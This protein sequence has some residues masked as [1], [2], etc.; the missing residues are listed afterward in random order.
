MMKLKGKLSVMRYELCT[1][2]YAL[3]TKLGTCGALASQHSRNLLIRKRSCDTVEQRHAFYGQ[4]TVRRG[5]S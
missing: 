5:N 3:S 2:N 4:G 1:I